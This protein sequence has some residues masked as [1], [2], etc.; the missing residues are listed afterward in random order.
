[1]PPARPARFALLLLTGCSL[2]PCSNAK[3]ITV[4]VY[5]VENLFDIDGV[6]EF[7]Q[8]G[9]LFP[10]DEPDY[11]AEM[12]SRKL[13]TIAKVLATVND[14]AGPDV[15]AF[16]EFETD[17]TPESTV[18]DY[19]AFLEKH[20]GVTVAQMLTEPVTAEVKGLPVTPLLVKR[21][22]EAGLG[23]YRVAL[24]KMTIP[25]GGRTIA[26]QNAVLS[27]L[28]ITSNKSHP[29]P[30]ARDLLEVTVDAEGS[31][32]TI[33]NNHW[34]SG[35]SDPV[36][37]PIRVE[38]ARLVRARL[39]EILK[40]DPAADV[41]VVGDFN[42]YYNQRDIVRE[43]RLTGID[44]VLG[45]Q[46]DERAL[47]KPDSGKDLYNLWYDAPLGSR[48]SEVWRGRRSTLMQALVTPG[49][50]DGRGVQY[51]D[52]SF[53]RLQVTGVNVD[54][55]GRPLRWYFAY[56]GGGGSDHLPVAL[57]LSVVGDS[58]A[59]VK[60]TQPDSGKRD[61]IYWSPPK[62][63]RQGS[64]MPFDPTAADAQQPEWWRKRIGRLIEF[65]GKLSNTSPFEMEIGGAEFRLWYTTRSLR[66]KLDGVRPG[67][68]LR[69]R[70]V[71]LAYENGLAIDVID[72]DW[73]TVSERRRGE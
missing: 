12:L 44:R 71:L 34:K 7:D 42:S 67:A 9:P 19:D 27:R 18:T 29:L 6:A 10:G 32:L 52:N 40:E 46:G 13:D 72:P 28:P 33:L 2:A 62:E 61:F 63:G 1:M 11:N 26:H 38:N 53:R 59:V 66:D 50:Y 73:V 55:L 15:I 48:F 30:S 36:T 49:L 8:Y 37:E 21:L 4:V 25:E 16:Q 23:R 54:D 31:P 64:P 35:A 45:S 3:E 41:L 20:R 56:G 22:E 43:A 47:L 68:S 5:N 60:P 70:G 39:D 24:G 58:G 57:D 65:E 17:Q 14:G 51:V 69:G